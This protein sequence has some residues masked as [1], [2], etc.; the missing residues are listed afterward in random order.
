MEQPAPI[1]IFQPTENDSKA[2]Y[3][4]PPALPPPSASTDE[5]HRLI[6]FLESQKELHQAMEDTLRELE[7]GYRAIVENIP[8][9]VYS[10]NERGVIVM[11]NQAVVTYGYSVEEL[12]GSYFPDLIYHEDRE[13]TRRTFFDIAAQRKNCAHSQKFRI[14]TKTGELR[15]LEANCSIHFTLNGDFIWQEG[16]CRDITEI[17]QVQHSLMKIQDD[18]E[19]QVR[20]RTFELTRANTELHNEIQER[21]DT[22]RALRERE[23]DLEQEKV[24]LQEANTALKVLLKRRDR[25]KRTLEEQVMYNVKKLLLPYLN[26]LSREIQDE[27]HKAYLHIIETN[28]QDITGSFSRRLSMEYYGLTKAEIKVANFIRQ[29][30]KNRQIADLMG[31]S[32]RTVEAYRMSIREKLKIHNKKINLCTYLMSIA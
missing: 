20:K 24:N 15:W 12:V 23:K 27:R 13:S 6:S 31:L 7:R 22:E 4:S 3:T 19:E 32:I 1:L 25:D 8:D 16:V 29:G 18:L 11:I 10:L 26:K 9:L 21:R 17:I 5:L 2:P 14:V 28:L 30:N